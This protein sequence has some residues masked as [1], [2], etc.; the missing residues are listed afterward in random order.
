M[1]KKYAILILAAGTSR[2]LGS[3]KQLVKIG[4]S[5]LL[6]NTIDAALQIKNAD[7]HVVIGAYADIV[8]NAIKINI[9]IHINPNWKIGMGNSIA[10]G[11]EKIKDQGYE[12]VVL[13]VCDQ[14]YLKAAHLESLIRLYEENPDVEIIVSKYRTGSGPPSFFKQNYFEHLANLNG[15]EGAKSIVKSYR[16]ELSYISF[17]KG[18]IDVDTKEDLQSPY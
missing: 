14:P 3:P 4:N 10:F 8:L 9:P 16:G 1:S 15:E 2:R 13:S 6:S 7:T 5:N 18:D 17:D 11:I 12:G